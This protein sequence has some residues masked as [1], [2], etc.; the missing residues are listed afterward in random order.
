MYI[1]LF[2]FVENMNMNMNMIRV[3]TLVVFLIFIF[4]FF[5]AGKRW[6]TGTWSSNLG[7][8][9]RLSLVESV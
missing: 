5:I 8:V 6:V 1:T 9:C 4:I 7:L 2:S 3:F